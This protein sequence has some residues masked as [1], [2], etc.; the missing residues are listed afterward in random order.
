[1][2]WHSWIFC[3]FYQLSDI[4]GKLWK[5]NFTWYSWVIFWFL[6]IGIKKYW[7]KLL[8]FLSY[9]KEALIFFK[10]FQVR[11][12]HVQNNLKQ[13]FHHRALL[14]KLVKRIGSGS[15]NFIKSKK[16]FNPRQE[17]HPVKTTFT[18]VLINI[19][20]K[21]HQIQFQSFF[22]HLLLYQTFNWLNC[23]FTNQKPIFNQTKNI[24]LMIWQ[25]LNNILNQ[26][27]TYSWS[28]SSW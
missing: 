23:K 11:L 14:S 25:H 12:I 3:F 17:I 15:T 27:G 8:I 20:T 9:K 13:S 5:S 24:L 4:V 18:R 21:C 10:I 2:I 22:W 6:L 26:F 1:M 7:N 16:N 19:S 28:I